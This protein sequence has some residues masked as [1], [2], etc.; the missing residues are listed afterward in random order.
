MYGRHIL[1]P[2]AVKSPEDVPFGTIWI[3]TESDGIDSEFLK[4][5]YKAHNQLIIVIFLL[6]QIFV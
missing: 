2:A 3:T 1:N 6:P 5:T 4:D